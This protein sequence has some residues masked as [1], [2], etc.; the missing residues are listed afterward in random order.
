MRPRLTVE[1]GSNRARVHGKNDAKCIGR[2]GARR[3]CLANKK[4]ILL[5]KLAHWVS[6][7]LLHWWNPPSPYVCLPK[8][9]CGGSEFKMIGIYARRIVASVKHVKGPV[10]ITKRKPVRESVSF[11]MLRF[12]SEESIAKLMPTTRP[13]PAI[14]RA[15]FDHFAPKAALYFRATLNVSYPFGASR[16][17]SDL[18]CNKLFDIHDSLPACA[19]TRRAFLFSQNSPR[20]QA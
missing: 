16:L 14:I 13:Y 11:P 2:V 20:I 6:L 15:F 3:V 12:V 5:G 10:E 1:D 9:F 17:P 7:S 8:I 4:N 18:S 19:D